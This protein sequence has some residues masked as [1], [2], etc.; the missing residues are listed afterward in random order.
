M[1]VISQLKEWRPMNLDSSHFVHSVLWLHQ[2]RRSRA[3]SC[4][5]SPC[6]PALS[7]NPLL[8]PRNPESSTVGGRRKGEENGELIW[9]KIG[10]DL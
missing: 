6:L 10:T 4:H 8:V 1:G 5:C 3:R 9:G 7:H 2:S